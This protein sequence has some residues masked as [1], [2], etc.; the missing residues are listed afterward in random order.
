[1]EVSVFEKKYSPVVLTKASMFAFHLAERAIKFVLQDE[2]IRFLHMT[3]DETKWN[4]PNKY[5]SD[6]PHHKSEI[7]FSV[8]CRNDKVVEIEADIVLMKR[9]DGDWILPG[10]IESDRLRFPACNALKGACVYF[11]AHH[12][13]GTIHRCTLWYINVSSKEGS[14]PEDEPMREV[15]AKLLAT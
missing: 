2:M 1:M 11:G 9:D 10:R 13:T 15:R 6:I 8:L 7:T 3:M 14:S 4:E 5:G 12:E